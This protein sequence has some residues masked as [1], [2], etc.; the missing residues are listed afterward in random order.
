MRVRVE[1]FLRPF[2]DEDTDYD[3]KLLTLRILDKERETIISGTPIEYSN[4]YE[5]CWK[6]EPD[7]RP[8]IQDVV[9][10]L[11]TINSSKQSEEVDSLNQ[12]SVHSDKSYHSKELELDI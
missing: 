4:L 5:Q 10:T 9:S 7:E 12:P 8:S 11:K 2:C 1:I 3:V 6:Y